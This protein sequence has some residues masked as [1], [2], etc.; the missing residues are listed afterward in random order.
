[1]GFKGTAG[2]TII[3][4]V[5]LYQPKN[6]QETNPDGQSGAVFDLKTMVMEI[7]LYE[8][9]FSPTMYGDIIITDAINAIEKFPIYGTEII[10]I[11]LRTTQLENEWGNLIYKSFQL[12]KV[13]NMILNGDREA[14]YKLCFTSLETYRDKTAYLTNRFSGDTATL[15]RRI[16][17]QHI[18]KIENNAS[19]QLK[20]IEA[21]QRGNAN[22][23]PLYVGDLNN[24]SKHGNTITYVSNYWTPFQN[25]N[26]IA[27][28]TVGNSLKSPSFLFY[29][30]NKGFYFTSLEWNV[31]RRK[32]FEEYHFLPESMK[33]FPRRSLSDNYT[34]N[35]LPEAYTKINDMKVASRIDI[36]KYYNSGALANSVMSYEF[37]TK[38][39]REFTFDLMKNWDDYKHTG[40]GIPIPYNTAPNPFSRRVW[41]ATDLN[42]FG[43]ISADDVVPSSGDMFETNPSTDAYTSTN[44][45]KLSR[46]GQRLGYLTGFDQ[47]TFELTVPGRTDI[48]VGACIDILYPS[49]GEKLTDTAGDIY[50]E[51]L[52]GRY[53]ISSIH[54]RINYDDH[55]MYM[56]VVKNGINKSLGTEPA[57]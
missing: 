28:N 40:G 43:D 29:E 27:K 7:N 49:V 57:G 13:S 56:E 18:N 6:D 35:L 11:K 42:R 10:T 19:T 33:D 21:L 23:T 3:E 17:N 41:K 44:V 8:D 31:D 38:K 15:A 50:D 9:V 20:R 37:S 54:H 48:E 34:G 39:I 51:M 14:I 12:Y 36:L 30:S 26:Y 32:S 25:L 22:S 24:S 47:F 55:V 46:A 4:E 53:L 5:L 1:M 52:S 16:Y 45:N 2:E